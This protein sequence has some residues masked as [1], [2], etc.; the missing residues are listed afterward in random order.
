MDG[1]SYLLFMIVLVILFVII[2]VA[3]FVFWILMLIDSIKRNFKK[4]N[5]KIIWVLVIVLTGILGA[6]IYYFVIKRK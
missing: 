3:A 4:E 2:C 6:I 5:D 1:S